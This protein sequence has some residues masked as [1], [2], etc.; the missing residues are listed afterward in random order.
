MSAGGYAAIFSS[1]L[2]SPAALL[3]HRQVLDTPRN[4]NNIIEEAYTK[5][6]HILVPLR[7]IL[8]LTLITN[9]SV[10]RLK[11]IV[12]VSTEVPCTSLSL[13]ACRLV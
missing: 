11:S 8:I 10:V 3:V 2:G 6:G 13:P 4:R 5:P 9:I 7:T 12:L 1:G